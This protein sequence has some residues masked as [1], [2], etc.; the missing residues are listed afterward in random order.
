MRANLLALLVVVA[1]MDEGETSDQR[2][3]GRAGGRLSVLVSGHAHLATVHLTAEQVG[4]T[5]RVLYTFFPAEEAG[6]VP[7][8]THRRRWELCVG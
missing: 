8:R 2:V 6:R 7:G 4:P 5:V 3:R 1:A